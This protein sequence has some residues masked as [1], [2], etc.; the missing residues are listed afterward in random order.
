MSRLPP[1]SSLHARVRN[2]ADDEIRTFSFCEATA[3]ANH[4][5]VGVMPAIGSILSKARFPP[6]HR[7]N[8]YPHLE[9]SRVCF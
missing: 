5:S 9:R 3:W 1:P 6:K 2:I 4:G 8:R 7:G